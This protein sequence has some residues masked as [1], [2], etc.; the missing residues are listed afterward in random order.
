[1]EAVVAP[2]VATRTAGRFPNPAAELSGVPLSYVVT[3]PDARLGVQ[4]S[5]PLP[6]R[7]AL[8]LARGFAARRVNL[9]NGHALALPRGRWIAQLEVELES[10]GRLPPDFLQL[11]LR[12]G[13][14][15]R[16]VEPPLLDVSLG[17][18][19]DGDLA[20]EVHAWDAVGLLASVLGRVDAVGLAPAEIVLETEGECAFHQLTLR[21]RAGGP[22]SA[23][24]RRRL[25]RSLVEQ[26][27]SR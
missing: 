13:G 26:L 21:D 3:R 11:A 9:R 19:A 16:L 25:A 5:G 14:G 20:V 18:D 27:R 22:A 12:D 24:Q 2:A 1:M 8:W 7:W 4:L 10:G 15:P 23:R 6:T 17:Q